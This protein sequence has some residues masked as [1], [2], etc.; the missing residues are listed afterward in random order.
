MQ[1]ISPT[2]LGG[3]SLDVDGLVEQLVA[4]EGSPAQN[5]L[6]RKEVELQTN[7]SALGAFRGSLAD[8]QNSLTALRDA[9]G[10]RDIQA[11]S[12]DEDKVGIIASNQA[13]ESEYELE[14]LQLAQPQRLLSG[15]FKSELDPV[16]SGN[17][18]IQFG[19]V[20][21]ST[22]RF[23]V[24][25]KLTATNIQIDEQNNSLRGVAQAINRADA[26]VRASLINDGS[27]FRLTLSSRATGEI[28]AMRIIVDDTDGGHTDRRG[29]SR[30]AYD[31]VANGNRHL[32]ETAEA[33]DAIVRLD[34]IEVTSPTNEISNAIQGVT[35]DLK[36]HT[37][38]EV[39]RLS[40]KQDLQK[41]QD[42]IVG[43]VEIYNN[44]IDT[45]QSI[46]G[47]DPETQQAGPLSG[48]SA[49]R[50]IADQVRRV[51]GTSFNGINEDYESLA[52]IGIETQRDGKLV[53]N[54]R[55]LRAA[56]MDDLQQVSK[57]FARTGVASDSLISFVSADDTAVMGVHEIS[58]SET[59]R[60]G[61]YISAETGPVANF[62]MSEEENHL[63]LKVDGV[64]SS[65]IRL[66]AGVYTSG[67]D[68]AAELQR[69]I[70]ND[71]VLRREGA[72]V[73]VEFVAG[74]FVISSNRVGSAS[75]VDVVSAGDSV[76][77]LGID[78]A[79][80]LA[81]ADVAGR[82]GT[83]PAVG[84]GTRLTG[85]GAASGISVDVLGG[86]AGP[87][88]TVGFSIGVAEQL[89]DLL[90]SYLAP[91]GMLQSR[92]DGLN[93]RIEDIGRQREQLGRRLAVSEQRLMKQFSNLDAML[94]RMRN[95]SQFLTNQ[96]AGLP[97]AN[98]QSKDR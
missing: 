63:M 68:L 89:A 16:G 35:I 77:R 12:S 84:N 75:R 52:A 31:P 41:V 4:A 8:F 29:L 83:R 57:L 5:R 3:S 18:S 27:G 91:G 94:G 90:D 46:A 72:G 25:D 14:V 17:L 21:T 48:D 30:L 74:Q 1:G 73:S 58:I 9:A 69:Q 10:F 55:A 28:N 42:S 44:L 6:D 50:G 38:G 82:I 40:T 19:R 47:F 70:N 61:K 64:A 24:N 96:L 11:S 85:Q 87:R 81:G 62:I 79:N 33:R 20:D 59:G 34:G 26:G 65:S 49:V 98:T 45:I 15:S 36:A 97:G 86:R 66:S 95:T 78:P 88:G 60:S 22:G 67:K 51:I 71:G 7:I 32:I 39:V 43:F 54:D 92:S 56:L 23:I 13:Q 93:A 2:G 37:G 80:G 76:R 53:I